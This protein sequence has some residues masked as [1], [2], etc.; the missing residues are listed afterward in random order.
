MEA[1]LVST[2]VVALAEMGDKTQL[3]TISLAVQ[4]RAPFA[5]VAGTTAGMLIA[6][7]IGIVI[8]V[9]MHKHIPQ[10]F[11]HAFSAVIFMLFGLAGTYQFLIAHVSPAVSWAA[12]GAL[13]LGA[14][15][16]SRYILGKEGHGS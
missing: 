10:S 3:A 4:F 7:A 6:D 12:V 5:G 1:F 15:I 13:A 16:A 9:L 8:G 14:F 2:G 11:V